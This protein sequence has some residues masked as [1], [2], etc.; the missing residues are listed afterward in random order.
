MFLFGILSSPLPYLLI[1]AFYFCG[2]AVGMFHKETSDEDKHAPLQIKNIQVDNHLIIQKKAEN[3]FYF[4][5]YKVEKKV[6]DCNIKA[7][8]TPPSSKEKLIYFVHDIK[9]PHTSNSDFHFCRP[10]PSQG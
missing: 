3:S 8:K 1:A 4:H 9:I 10:P 6:V 7:L 2:F 5:Q